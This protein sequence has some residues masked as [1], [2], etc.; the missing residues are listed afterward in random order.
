MRE[1]YGRLFDD[2]SRLP[3]FDEK[4]KIWDVSSKFKIDDN[5]EPDYLAGIPDDEGLLSHPFLEKML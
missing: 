4:T 2:P 5:D 3:Y 1:K